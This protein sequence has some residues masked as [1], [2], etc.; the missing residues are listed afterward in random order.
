MEEILVAT[1]EYFAVE[2]TEYS[3]DTCA[4]VLKVKKMVFSMGKQ[5]VA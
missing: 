5:M 1:M 2:K 3:T 4:V